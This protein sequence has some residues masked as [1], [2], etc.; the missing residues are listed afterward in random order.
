MP[1]RPVT[2]RSAGPAAGVISTVWAN[3]VVSRTSSSANVVGSV[4]PTGTV[5]KPSSR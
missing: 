4:V 2:S 3:G 1:L 5:W